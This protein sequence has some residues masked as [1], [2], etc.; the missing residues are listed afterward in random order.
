MSSIILIKPPRAGQFWGPENIEFLVTYTLL[1]PPSS[2]SSLGIQASFFL[3][4][5][6]PSL[7]KSWSF[8]F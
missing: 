7:T 2:K 3:P 1:S 5:C 4:A 6:H 8:Q